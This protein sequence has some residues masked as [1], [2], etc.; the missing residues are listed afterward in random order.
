MKETDELGNRMKSYERTETNRRLDLTK[1]MYAR[2]DGRAFHT[3][4]KNMSKPFDKNISY[5]MIEA[6][7]YLTKETNARIGYTQ[8]DEISLIW[9]ISP[10]A[11]YKEIPENIRNVM[12][13][14]F[15]F[16]GKIQKLTSI[17]ASMAT[18]IFNKELNT[19][20]L[21]IFD[22]RIFNLP[23]EV[24][25]ANCLLWRTLDARK[26]AIH[27][28]ARKHFTHKEI[29]NKSQID[30]LN[31]LKEINVDIETY[32][33]AFTDGTF[34]QRRMIERETVSTD[35]GIESVMRSVYQ[36]IDMPFFRNVTN[37]IEVIFDSQEPIER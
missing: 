34:I 18:V 25:A 36:P 1:P 37:R 12:P 22:A 27:S 10:P 21:P 29:Q 4:T 30:M 24:E 32:P 28:L 3:L 7:K 31:M 33:K 6:T 26:N 8:S 15:I 13:M 14:R 16:D 5:A 19:D 9:K 17:L 35:L 20:K 23:T 11:H 2:I